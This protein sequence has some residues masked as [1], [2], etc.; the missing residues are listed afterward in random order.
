MDLLRKRFSGELKKE[1]LDFSSSLKF[2]KK[3]YKYD[4]EGSIAH[5][6]M[7]GKTK[8]ITK[9]DALRIVAGL[10]AIK[11]ALE[12]GSISLDG[13]GEDVHMA[14]ESILTKKIGDAGKKLHTARSRNDQVSV[15]MRLFMRAE[16]LEVIKL[17]KNMQESII[18]LA[19][20]NLDAVMPGYTHMQHA[21][22]I[23]FSHYI[24]SYFYMLERDKERIKDSLK[25]INV[26]TLGAGPIAGT[27]FPI[28]R[29]FTAKILGF[30]HV[31]ENSIDSVS[32]RDF[33]IETVSVL[34][35]I[36]I[37]LSRFAEDLII[38]N[39]QEFKFI[40]IDDSFCTGSSI[41]PQKKN[42]DILELVRGKSGRVFGNLSA[43]MM[44]MKGLPLSY[45]RDMQEDKEQVFGAIETTK[46]CLNMC[47]LLLKKTK[48]KKDSMFAAADD[49]FSVAT[50]LAEYLV[51]KQVP[52][53]KAYGCVSGLVSYAI[54]KNKNLKELTL[55]ELKLFSEKFSQDVFKLLKT[56]NS[57]DFKKSS[58]STSHK[59]VVLQIKNAKMLLK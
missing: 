22:P 27:T 23:L 20:K 19:Q 10:Q 41:M 24:M 34:T 8:I 48:I 5:A 59:E 40:E 30:E 3:L 42:P 37:H 36:M 6:K 16:S 57:V 17:I 50:D 13:K 21:Q 39:S 2:D 1:A 38:W 56:S 26:L 55:N 4:I 46:E 58:G 53:R 35:L 7:L 49:G 28:D 45:N 14:I 9:K 47:A 18:S 25:R 32:D 52:F 44:I 15:D 43:L 51:K 31:S 54:K 29:K 12:K 33:A 11:K